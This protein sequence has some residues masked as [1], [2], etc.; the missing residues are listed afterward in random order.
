[1]QSK[2]LLLTESNVTWAILKF[3]ILRMVQD[4][5]NAYFGCIQHFIFFAKKLVYFLIN[6]FFCKGKVTS[7]ILQIYKLSRQHK[8]AIPYCVS[9]NM[10]VTIMSVIQFLL[11]RS[12]YTQLFKYSEF[13]KGTLKYLIC[14]LWQSY[15]I[16]CKQYW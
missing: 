13:E 3:E 14:I 10:Y 11:P 12:S 1:M 16:Q 7:W 2:G 4:F 15:A 6:R 9:S 5:Q 8:I